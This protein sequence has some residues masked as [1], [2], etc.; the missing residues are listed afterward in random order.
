MSS[1][2][3]ASQSSAPD[4]HEEE[5]TDIAGNVPG[6]TVKQTPS[7]QDDAP[8]DHDAR[9]EAGE[10][11]ESISNGSNGLT[12]ARVRSRGTQQEEETA[13]QLSIRPRIERP[14]SPSSASIPDDTPSIQVCPARTTWQQGANS[15]RAQVCRRLA[16]ASPSLTARFVHI[17]LPLSSPS[18]DASLRDFHPRH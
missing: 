5:D 1:D 14:D 6:D 2:S 7:L 10:E 9:D 12:F 15:H 18:N 11:L 16:A 13:S 8:E 17:A 4:N 3:E